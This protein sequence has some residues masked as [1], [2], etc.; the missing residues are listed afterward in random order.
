M[1]GQQQAQTTRYQEMML[2]SSKDGMEKKKKQ[3]ETTYGR[4]IEILVEVTR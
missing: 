3:V 2:E 4:H 1:T